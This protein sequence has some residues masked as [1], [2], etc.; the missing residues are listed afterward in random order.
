MA[1]GLE[2][3]STYLDSEQWKETVLSHLDTHEKTIAEAIISLQSNEYIQKMSH[4]R[5]NL[6]DQDKKKI[7]EWWSMS[8]LPSVKRMLFNTWPLP[9]MLSVVFGKTSASYQ[10]FDN[11]CVFTR[12][13]VHLGILG[14]PQWISDDDMKE[15]IA[16]DA[17]GIRLQFKAAKWLCTVVPEL[18]P[19]LPFLQRAE[20]FVLLGSVAQER[21]LQAVVNTPKHDVIT[22]SVKDDVYAAF[23][24][25]DDPYAT[26]A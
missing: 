6:S 2:K 16:D 22:T 23:A 9:R 21:I 26:A 13:L 1:W 25:A 8:L 20:P 10:L 14:K 4:E 15:N 19:A 11:F 17:K 7:Y 12:V 24:A 18:R 3:V 5:D